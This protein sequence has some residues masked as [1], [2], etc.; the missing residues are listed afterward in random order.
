M[1]RGYAEDWRWLGT[2]GL[3]AVLFGLITLIWPHLTLWALVVLWAI[4][5][6]ADGVFVLSA[7]LLGALPGHRM[8]WVV[9]AAVGIGAG[10][11]TL[12]WP[13]ITALALLVVIA[14]WA[15]AV[16]AVQVVTAFRYRDELLH[17]AFLAITGFLSVLLAI[18]L[19]RN[20]EAGA[21]AITWAIGW[22][23]TVFG[24]LLFVMA[25]EQ[26]GAERSDSSGTSR[27]GRGGHS[28][29]A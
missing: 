16:G 4:F 24:S 27:A 25:W 10:V 22:F 9:Y 26:R 23:A 11:I 5:V 17:P 14:L 29:A 15:L 1:T 7:A 12:I 13:S 8:G 2:R 6:I 3:A 28:P 21:L 19:L 18:L 20:P